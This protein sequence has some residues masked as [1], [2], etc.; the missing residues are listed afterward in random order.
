MVLILGVLGVFEIVE[1]VFWMLKVVLILLV[2]LFKD[3][4]VGLDFDLDGF[5]LVIVDGDFDFELD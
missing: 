5:F 3:Y 4:D 2:L 1:V